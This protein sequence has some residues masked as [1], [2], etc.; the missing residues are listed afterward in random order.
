MVSSYLDRFKDPSEVSSYELSEYAPG[1]YASSIW[2]LQQPI[3]ER[4]IVD[5][6]NRKERKLRLLDFAC[7]TGRIISRVEPLVD[8]ADGVD[9]SENMIRLARKKCEQ[10]SLS[11]GDIV[12]QPE[13]IQGPYNIITCFRFILNVEAEVRGRV[14]RRLREAMREPDGLLLVNIH[15]NSQSLRHVA[16]AWRRRRL[17]HMPEVT[18]SREMLNEMS[19]SE[20]RALLWDSGFKVIQQIGCGILPR[21]AYRTP[22]RKIGVM[23]DR[24]VSDRNWCKNWSVD[25]IFVCEPK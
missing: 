6:R 10:A 3:L 2:E 20:A 17:R 23:I 21:A 12:T 22:F 1:S 16:L 8:H 4:I 11:V 18:R 15:G 25:I 24:F 9:I 5:F 7:G 14:L 19:P 13:L